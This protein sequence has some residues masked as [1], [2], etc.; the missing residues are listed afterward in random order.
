ME[1]EKPN[2]ILKSIVLAVSLLT[3]SQL[4]LVLLR[5]QASRSN[6]NCSYKI[7]KLIRIFAGANDV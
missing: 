1:N 7:N 6:L 3:L 5:R 4:L 2:T